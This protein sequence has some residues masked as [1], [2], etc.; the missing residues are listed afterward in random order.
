MSATTIEQLYEQHIKS[1]SVVD[2]LRLVAIITQHLQLSIE[3]EPVQTGERPERSLLELGGA[4]ADIWPG[5]DAQKSV[6]EL[7][8]KQK[9]S[10]QAVLQLAGTLPPEEAEV[11]L[12]AAQECRQIDWELWE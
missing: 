5:V 6:D 9:G 2:Q 7:D 8:G 3:S 12:Q 11:I 1:M 4:E 10:P